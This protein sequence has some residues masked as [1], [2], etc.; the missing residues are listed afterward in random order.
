MITSTASTK[1]T[2]LEVFL[3]SEFSEQRKLT[4]GPYG[5][6]HSAITSL[7]DRLGRTAVIGDLNTATITDHL[8][9]LQVRRAE[10]T[11]YKQK[12]VLFVLWNVAY[13]IGILPDAPHRSRENDTRIEASAWR[14][15]RLSSA[16]PTAAGPPMLAEAISDHFAIL[17]KKASGSYRMCLQRINSALGRSATVADLTTETLDTFRNYLVKENLPDRMVAEKLTAFRKIWRTFHA[18]RTDVLPANR[19]A[20]SSPGKQ[21]RVM[22][23]MFDEAFPLTGPADRD[24]MTFFVGV[25]SLRRLLGRSEHTSQK[26]L[27]VIRNFGRFLKRRPTLDDLN[28]DTIPAYLQVR[29]SERASCTAESERTQLVALASYAAKKRLIPTFIEIRPLPTSADAPNAW[30]PDELRRLLTAYYHAPG[31]IDGLYAGQ[32]FYALH[33]VALYCGE[34]SGALFKLRWEWLDRETGSLSVPGKARKGRRKLM[35]YK[36]P[37]EVLA[38]VNKLW[39]PGREYVFLTPG[40]VSEATIFY[41]MTAIQRNAGLPHGRRDKLHRMRRTF[42]SLIEKAG[43]DA[44]AAL[45]HSSRR[46]TQDSYL[47]EAL[48]DRP[49]PS[50]LIVKMMPA[51]FGLGRVSAIAGPE[52]PVR[53]AA[54]TPP[55]NAAAEPEAVDWTAFV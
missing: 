38:E 31:L 10:G 24:L 6:F 55:R 20:V 36:L 32:W 35:S 9:K 33:L 34:R 46:V 5:H 43:G 48:I 11:A 44:T 45:A 7:S 23:G 15:T 17:K 16:R 52:T 13:D 37:P 8:E 2:P 51:E 4:V 53:I 14:P 19:Q 39:R 1:D 3:V 22:P 18:S 26:Y 47:D 50:G 40:V 42:A 28:E 12:T 41:K 29:M 25:Y 49:A 27:A 21:P 30:K 54:V